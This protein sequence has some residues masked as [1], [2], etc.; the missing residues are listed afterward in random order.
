[1]GQV[2]RRLHPRIIDM[3][4]EHTMRALIT[5]LEHTLLSLEPSGERPERRMAT[6]EALRR[7]L[8]LQRLASNRA[9]ELEREGW[10][11]DE[12]AFFLEG[13]VE[14]AVNGGTRTEHA[15]LQGPEPYASYEVEVSEVEVSEVEVSV[16]PLPPAPRARMWAPYA[17]YELAA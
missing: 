8:D 7:D 3:R 4:T 17:S 10:Q 13:V 14:D 9:A 11:A 6:V 15:L 12:A 1:M 5:D 2:A 16:D